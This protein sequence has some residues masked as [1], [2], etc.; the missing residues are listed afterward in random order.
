M[1]IVEGRL[2]FVQREELL[3]ISP[4]SYLFLVE[5]PEH[6][7]HTIIPLFPDLALEPPL[8]PLPAAITITAR[9]HY[10][11]GA[12]ETVT[13]ED[14]CATYKHQFEEVLQQQYLNLP[15]DPAKVG[16]EYALKSAFLTAI[17]KWQ[18]KRMIPW[19]AMRVLFASARCPDRY[20]IDSP[21][22][23]FQQIDFLGPLFLAIYITNI[24][25]GQITKEYMAKISKASNKQIR[26]I[27]DSLLVDEKLK[28]S[29]EKFLAEARTEAEK[30]N[31]RID[32]GPDEKVPHHITPRIQ[33]GN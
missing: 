15:I 1:D 21:E 33:Q 4:R 12:T 17:Q 6:Q 14:A 2:Y 26:M 29:L 28:T 27:I 24:S 13:L 18:E 19:N 25:G 20:D 10:S 5:L 22:R 16:E 11:N 23:R 32:I 31:V 30:K 8:Q 7:L 3:I 9:L